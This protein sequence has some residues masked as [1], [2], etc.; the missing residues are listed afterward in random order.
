MAFAGGPRHPRFSPPELTRVSVVLKERRRVEAWCR[1]SAIGGQASRRDLHPVEDLEICFAAQ[2][3]KPPFLLNSIN[4]LQTD[5]EAN[6]VGEAIISKL[7]AHSETFVA[8][9]HLIAFQADLRSENWGLFAFKHCWQTPVVV[10]YHIR[11]T[12]PMR[13]LPIPSFGV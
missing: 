1:P 2:P 13:A 8:N 11:Y 9:F 3:K 4:T 12:S 5:R 6:C 10:T 7:V